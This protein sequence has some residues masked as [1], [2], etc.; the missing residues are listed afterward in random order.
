MHMILFVKKGEGCLE[1]AGDSFLQNYISPTMKNQ[2]FEDCGSGPK[3]L[4][5][6]SEAWFGLVLHPSDFHITA[7]LQEGPCGQVF[8][9]L[10]RL[11]SL[12]CVFTVLV[13]EPLCKTF[14]CHSPGEQAE[15]STFGAWFSPHRRLHTCCA[16]PRPGSGEITVNEAF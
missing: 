12:W 7:F 4:G 6:L 5:V 14:S 15:Q 13:H 1:T 2:S 3:A 16:M 11:L 8:S 10:T 9:W